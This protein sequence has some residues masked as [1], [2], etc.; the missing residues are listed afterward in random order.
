MSDT[1]DEK[2]QD[3][4]PAEQ[5]DTVTAPDTPEADADSPGTEQPPEEKPAEESQE[6]VAEPTPDPAPEPAPEPPRPRSVTSTCRY[7]ASD[8]QGRI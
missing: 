7:Q 1:S 5:S 8:T 3:A 4:P 6:P 2:P